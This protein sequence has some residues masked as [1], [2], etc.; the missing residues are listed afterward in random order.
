MWGTL[1]YAAPE[2]CTGL[3][4]TTKAD[5]W[6]YGCVLFEL[7][8]GLPPFSASTESTLI[9]RIVT[10]KLPRLPPMYSQDLARLVSLCLRKDPTKRPSALELMCLPS[11][12]CVAPSSRLQPRPP[13]QRHSA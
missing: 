5:V 12:V 1:L 7:C 6:S 4:Y 3:D 10:N 13:P 11:K 2:V 8:T 9:H